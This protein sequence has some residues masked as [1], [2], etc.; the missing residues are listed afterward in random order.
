V[1]KIVRQAGFKT[2]IAVRSHQAG[3]DAVKTILGFRGAKIKSING[4]LNGESVDVVAYDEDPIKFLLS[5]LSLFNVTRV[6]LDEEEHT[7]DICVSDNDINI[8]KGKNNTNIDLISSLIDWKVNVFSEKEWDEQQSANLEELLQNF[9]DALDVDEEIAT[10]LVENGFNTVEEVAYVPKDEFAELD[11][12][13]ETV[14]ELK[15][16]A[17]EYLSNQE[18]IAIEAKNKE[19]ISL[20]FSHDEIGELNKNEVY[21]KSDVADLGTFDLLD[22]LPT[23]GEDK[24]K[25]VIMKARDLV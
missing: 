3:L 6:S 12:D 7:I 1:V 15:A 14:A 9:I 24:A 22:F 23:M 16:R 18:L 4:F 2:K 10:L 19:L 13:D 25:D 20:G 21:N 17:K 11:L 5:G 8:V